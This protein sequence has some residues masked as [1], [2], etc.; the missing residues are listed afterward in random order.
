MCSIISISSSFSFH[1]YSVAIAGSRLCPSSRSVSLSHAHYHI[2]P[3]HH[4]F[5][6]TPLY[7]SVERILH[8][9]FVDT[10]VLLTRVRVFFFLFICISASPNH[11]YNTTV[12]ASSRLLFSYH[13]TAARWQ[14]FQITARAETVT[15]VRSRSQNAHNTTYG[16]AT[17][18]R[19]W[20]V[21]S[22]F[23]KGIANIHGHTVRVRRHTYD[24]HYVYTRA[25]CVYTRYLYTQMYAHNV[26]ERKQSSS[27]AA[28]TVCFG[29]SRIPPPPRPALVIRV[30]VVRQWR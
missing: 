15:S 30:S 13:A 28:D 4:L 20:R 9:A 5:I 18:R 1:R 26:C 12:L 23:P 24:M 3:A 21:K 6:N 16:F 25:Y 11:H 2:T 19:L 8:I 10:C 22:D 17:K 14:K 29:R 27:T 7:P